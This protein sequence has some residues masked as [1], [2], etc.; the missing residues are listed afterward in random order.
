[1]DA[2]MTTL[3]SGQRVY[4]AGYAQ[5][6]IPE[7][8]AAGATP[9]TLQQNVTGALAPLGTVERCEVTLLPSPVG[10]DG[11][12]LAVVL[13]PNQD[14]SAWSVS[15]RLL[16][17]LNFGHGDTSITL[18]TAEA[19]TQTGGHVS[20][21]G[22][23]ADANVRPASHVLSWVLPGN[24]YYVVDEGSITTTIPANSRAQPPVANPFAAAL[25]ALANQQSTDATE[26]DTLV[27]TH[28]A[29][30]AARDLASGAGINLGAW[31]VIGYTA[32]AIAG[33]FGLG[34]F[35]RSV[36]K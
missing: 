35:L 29:A 4:F 9:Q 23:I 20:I 25:G 22:R 8:R 7:L 13:V 3:A 21:T 31:E 36:V 14:V 17:G 2:L 30:N 27:V 26:N 16:Y 28:N 33:L 19:S 32:L 24:P 10:S 6:S 11:V 12:T 18:E 5:C 34:Y 1:M 15:N